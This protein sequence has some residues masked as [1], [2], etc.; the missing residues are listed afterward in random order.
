MGTCDR[1]KIVLSFMES[2]LFFCK[3]TCMAAH[4]ALE[5]IRVVN[6]MYKDGFVMVKGVPTENPKHVAWGKGDNHEFLETT[7]HLLPPEEGR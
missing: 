3:M 4:C 7:R 2:Q 5:H 6:I 1:Q